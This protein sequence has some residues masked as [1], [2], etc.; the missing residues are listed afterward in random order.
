MLPRGCSKSTSSRRVKQPL[1]P[2]R[3][4]LF[5]SNVG[6][7]SRTVDACLAPVCDEPAICLHVAV[8]EGMLNAVIDTEVVTDTECSIDID[9]QSTLQPTMITRSGMPITLS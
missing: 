5:N 4:L 6:S 3:P 9:D 8:H 1:M 2:D 7:P